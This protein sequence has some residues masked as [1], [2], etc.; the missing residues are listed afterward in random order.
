MPVDPSQLT[1]LSENIVREKYR[2][3]SDKG[4]QKIGK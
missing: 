2:V 1:E 4:A 3:S